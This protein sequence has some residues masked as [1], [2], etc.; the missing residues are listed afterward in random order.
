MPPRE[1]GDAGLG[2]RHALAD[3]VDTVAI[4]QRAAVEYYGWVSSG[5]D[6]HAL[7]TASSGR[8]AVAVIRVGERVRFEGADTESPDPAG[9]GGSR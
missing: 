8:R 5:D 7:L 9:T 2:G 6:S 3:F 4:V 1:L